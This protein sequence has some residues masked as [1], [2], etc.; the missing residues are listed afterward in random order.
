MLS[1][2]TKSGASLE[3]AEKVTAQVEGM[4]AGIA[5]DGVVQTV[6]LRERVLEVLKTVNPTAAA[7]FESYAKPVAG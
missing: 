2:I 5:V 6:Q 3:E 1:G 4:L 7:A